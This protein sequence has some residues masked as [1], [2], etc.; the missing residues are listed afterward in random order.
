MAE[1]L[2]NLMNMMSQPV[3]GSGLGTG[4]MGFGAGLQ[5]QGP[6][7]MQ[8]MQNQKLMDQRQQEMAGNLERE[9]QKSLFLAARTGLDMLDEEN[10][11]G[12]IQLGAQ[13]S[14]VL[15]AMGAD[16]SDTQRMTQLAIAA[17][18]GS[19]EAA[20]FLR[21]ELQT[22]V[23]IGEGMGIIPKPSTSSK[24]VGNVLVDDQ[25]GE[26]MFDARGQEKRDHTQDENGIL[27]YTDDGSR[28]FP[29]VEKVEAEL[30]DAE[31]FTRAS[32]IRGEINK[33]NADFTE[34]A[35]SWDRITASA[36]APSAAGD[37]ALIFNFMK[38]LDPGSTVREGEF[39]NA[40]NT[41]GVPGRIR[42]MYNRVQTGERLT[43]EQRAD[44]FG[45]AENIFDAA[46]TRADGIT[47]EY[48]RVAEGFG[49]NRE[50]VVID[51]GESPNISGAGSPDQVVEGTVIHNPNTGQYMEFRN[52]DW[53]EI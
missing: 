32:T 16:P 33:E 37:L 47:N 7:F 43:Q 39:A 26:V 2:G 10:Y 28:V 14:Q 42:A 29:Q 34:I 25:T 30:T 41:A 8:V 38:M 11:D 53:V 18:N 15:S 46:K 1:Q 48:V 52:G 27:R 50:D 20:D 4:L 3:T 49:I 23:Q 51:R 5:G 19:E 12:L 9:R 36:D 17:R 24:V 6:Q 35:N 22:A 13:R 31:R 44:F 45:Q 40:Q 21:G